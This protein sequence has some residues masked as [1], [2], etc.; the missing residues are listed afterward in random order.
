MAGITKAYDSRPLNADKQSAGAADAAADADADAD[1][2]AAA[3]RG[4]LC[5]DHFI[6]NQNSFIFTPISASGS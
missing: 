6:A 4:Y 3:E 1:T 2:D 5:F